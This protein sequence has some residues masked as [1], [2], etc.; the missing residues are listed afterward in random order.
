[1]FSPSRDLTGF[2]PAKFQVELVK[3]LSGLNGYHAGKGIPHIIR[4]I[5]PQQNI[6]VVFQSRLAIAYQPLHFIVIKHKVLYTTKVTKAIGFR[7]PG[8]RFHR[9]V[10]VDDIIRRQFA[11]GESADEFVIFVEYQPVHSTVTPYD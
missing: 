7:P 1:M 5:N 11:G 9:Q 8:T 6:L 4:T 3:N 10:I 2:W